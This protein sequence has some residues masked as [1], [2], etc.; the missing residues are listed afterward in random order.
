MDPIYRKYHH[1]LLTFSIM[2]AFSENY[3]SVLSHDEVVHGKCSMLNKHPG[4]YWQKFAGLRASYGYMYGHPGKKLLFMGGE[5]GQFIEWNFKE[6][7]DWHLLGYEMHNKMQLYVKDLNKLYTTEK[8]MYEVD[9][10]SGGFE[11]IDCNNNERGVVS[12]LRKGK[13][14]HDMLLFVC[15]FT[16][17]VYNDYRI[18]A[19]FDLHYDEILNSDSEIYG[20]S[21]VGNLG[22]VDA[23]QFGVHGR[24]YS[25][26]LQVPPLGTLIL[27]PNFKTI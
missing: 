22:G 10:E 21:N 26:K 25:L 19:P 23:E 9:F 5:F 14:W 7:L 11:W 20:G 3:V 6:S 24:P 16:P 27:K 4:D 8:A 13:D 17:V 15:N 12:F 18:G 1:N 2:Y